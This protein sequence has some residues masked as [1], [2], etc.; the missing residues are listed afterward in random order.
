MSDGAQD[1]LTRGIAAAKAGELKEARFFLEWVL[2][3]NP[4]ATQQMEAWL[5]LSEI[6]TDPAE[7]RA[8]LVEALAHDLSEP[9]ARRKLALLDGQLKPADLVNPETIPAIPTGDVTVETQRFTCPKCGGS[10][11]YASDGASLT[12]EYCE[13]RKSI[14]S[15]FEVEEGQNFSLAMATVQGHWKPAASKTV[16]CGGC[17]ANFVLPPE[18]LAITCPYCASAHVIES[19]ENGE[20]VVP[21]ALI[22]FRITA[23]QAV[24]ALRAWLD[25][26]LPEELQWKV[27]PGT[28][29]YI[30]VW[31]FELSGQASWRGYRRN[32]NNNQVIKD[33]GEMDIGRPQIRVPATHRLDP[34]CAP[35]LEAYDLSELTAYNEGYLA[36]WTAETYQIPVA[37]AAL[38]A[39]AKFF[40]EFK[41]EMRA[42]IFGSVE[43]LTVSSA[44]IKVDSFKLLLVP[45]W[46]TRYRVDQ[47]EYAV[48]IN[49]QTG[50][51]RA[52][53]PASGLKKL[54]NS[55]FGV[56]E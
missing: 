27:L 41:E 30:P 34:A 51:V 40:T 6:S 24:A 31:L 20:Y 52:N 38:D 39:R 46:L 8:W 22:P 44:G 45:A 50:Q 56:D 48:I 36:N 9:R 37:E 2:T 17:G 1:L 14:E 54:V 18:G 33:K 15:S 25:G 29:L 11:T 21:H 12:C 3:N 35:E 26:N 32:K 10:L 13:S 47:R 23:Q 19:V 5:W 4:D 55:I 53:R 28:G 16:Q 49:G 43:D 42:R 7:K